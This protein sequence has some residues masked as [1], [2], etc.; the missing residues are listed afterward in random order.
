MGKRKKM[1]EININCGRLEFREVSADERIGVFREADKGSVSYTN[2][3][4]IDKVS[5]FKGR[6]YRLWLNPNEV[7]TFPSRYDANIFAFTGW[8]SE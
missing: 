2:G 5:A 8:Y 7:V 6:P 4:K 1:D 3:F